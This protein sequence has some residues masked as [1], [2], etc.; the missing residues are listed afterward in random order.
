MI[1]ICKGAG[2]TIVIVWVKASGAL[3]PS[4]TVAVTV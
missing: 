1:R 3:S 4:A 2:A